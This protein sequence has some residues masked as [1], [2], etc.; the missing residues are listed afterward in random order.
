VLIEVDIGLRRC[1][2]P[3][4][5]VIDLAREINTLPGLSL[6]GAFTYPGQVYACRNE[7]EVEGIAAYECRI[8][9]DLAHRLEAVADAEIRVSGGSTPTAAHYTPGCG[10]TEIRAGTYVFNDRTQID[11]WSAAPDDCALCVLATVVSTPEHGRAVLDAGSKSVAADRA[12]ESPGSGML[13]EDGNA[14]L[15]KVNEEHGFLDLSQSEIDLHVGD[16]VQVIPNHA[17][18]VANLFDEIVA[19]RGGEVADTWK[20][21]GRGR[22]Q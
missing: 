3:P 22:L 11:R 17:C 19:V 1:G 7:N 15:V 12:P 4:E 14:V 20:I 2:V 6:V 10:L 18:V 8:M 21:A 9:A 13:L 5:Q 16:K